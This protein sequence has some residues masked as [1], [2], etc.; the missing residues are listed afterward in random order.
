MCATTI[1]SLGVAKAVGTIMHRIVN[2][3]KNTLAN[4]FMSTIVPPYSHN[5]CNAGCPKNLS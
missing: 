1:S 5:S 2:A 4:L 3:V